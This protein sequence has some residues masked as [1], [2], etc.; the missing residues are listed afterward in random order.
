MRKNIVLFGFMGTGKSRIGK[1]LSEKFGMDLLEMDKEIERR[2]SSSIND[3]FEKRGEAYFREAI[4][5][6]QAMVPDLFLTKIEDPDYT[7]RTWNTSQNTT[8]EGRTSGELV[9]EHIQGFADLFSVDFNLIAGLPLVAGMV[10]CIVASVLISNRTLPGIL[11]AVAIAIVGWSLGW[12]PGAM[13]AAGSLL[14]VLFI[15]GVLIKRFIPGV[16]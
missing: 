2:E 4:P 9:G 6:L 16:N 13:I 5:G 14:C 3:I 10:M 12:A 11:C 8:W 7:E 15:A 1:I